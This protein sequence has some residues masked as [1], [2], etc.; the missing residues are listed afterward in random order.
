MQPTPPYLA[1]SSWWW[2]QVSGATSPLGVAVRHV[3]CGDFFPPSY[4]ALWDSKTSHKLASESFLVFGNFSFMTPSP[5]W[6][7]IPNSFVSLFT[8]YILSY[9]LLK[10]MGCL[11]GCLLS[12]VSVQ[13][14]FCGICC[15]PMIFRW[16]CGGES[17]LP[18]LFLHHLRTASSHL[19]YSYNTLIVR[20][21]VIFPLTFWLF[22]FSFLSWFLSRTIEWGIS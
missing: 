18:V 8:Y 14:L 7:S 1:P 10:T 9:L 19:L 15:V 22:L 4:V 11:S 13:K 17:G 21:L 6:V 16:I 3:I 5:G 2:T 20:F 12:S